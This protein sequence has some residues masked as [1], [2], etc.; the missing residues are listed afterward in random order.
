LN[1][2]LGKERGKQKWK[3][4]QLVSDYLLIGEYNSFVGGHAVYPLGV[5]SDNSDI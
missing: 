1:K 4:K 5:S 2:E 3:D